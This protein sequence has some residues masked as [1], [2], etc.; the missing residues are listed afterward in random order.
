MRVGLRLFVL[1][2]MAILALLL[3]LAGVG[4]QVTA[5]VAGLGVLICVGGLAIGVL[6]GFWAVPGLLAGVGVWVV[7]ALGLAQVLPIWAA[8]PLFGVVVLLPL[9][10]VIV[11]G[12]DMGQARAARLAARGRGIREW[13]WVY[14]GRDAARAHPAF[15]LS[16]GPVLTCAALLAI[17]AVWTWGGVIF[18]P[19]VAFEALT[20]LAI[21]CKWPVAYPMTFAALVPAFPVTAP[22]MMYWA[23]GV[24]PN[25]IYR[26]RFERLVPPEESA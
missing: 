8:G 6:P 19:L 2:P 22:L 10:S 18:W 20:V 14:V 24:R 17:I 21:L 4:G 12:R 11:L 1:G 3:A 5:Q 7:P 9:W 13:Q 26:H 16:I 23:D 15:A 25:L